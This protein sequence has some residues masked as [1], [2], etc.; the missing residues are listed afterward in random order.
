MVSKRGCRLQD[1]HGYESETDGGRV[2][3]LERRRQAEYMRRNTDRL[4]LER[5][6]PRTETLERFCR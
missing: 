6:D 4:T 5:M 2:P 3:G 1:A